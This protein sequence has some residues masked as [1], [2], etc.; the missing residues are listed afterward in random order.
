MATKL[1]DRLPDTER[2]KLWKLAQPTLWQDQ[3]KEAREYLVKERSLSKEILRDFKIGY[4]PQHVRRK[5]GDRH[6]FA[7][8]VVL[9]IQDQYHN[10]VALSSRDWREDAYMK[11]FHESFTKGHYLFG[12]NIAKKHILRKRKV[13]IVEGELDV[14][15]LHSNGL[16]FSVAV[17]GSALQ[18]Y[19]ISLVA[20]YCKQVFIVFDGDEAGGRARTRTMEMCAK[21][22][23]Q[24]NYDLDIIPVS[25]PDRKDPDDIVRESGINSF[26]DVLRQAREQMHNLRGA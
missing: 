10:L 14:L 8:R 2:E 5:T 12:L 23:L 26:V 16:N 22:E 18:L 19:Q 7:G 13:V 9:P 25:L 6:E 20:R 15:S 4:V 24:R 1:R 11:F 17:L 3:G 21:H